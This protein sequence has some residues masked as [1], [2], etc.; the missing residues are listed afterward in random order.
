MHLDQLHL[1]W[2]LVFWGTILLFVLFVL[3]VLSFSYLTLNYFSDSISSNSLFCSISLFFFCYP[4]EIELINLSPNLFTPPLTI[5]LTAFALIN[6]SFSL[7]FCSYVSS[8]SHH[9]PN[10]I[11]PEFIH[12]ISLTPSIFRHCNLHKVQLSWSIF[13]FVSQRNTS[14]STDKKW[15]HHLFLLCCFEK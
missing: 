6:C 14:V 15:T 12:F 10:W 2:L 9:C 11:F 3:S 7:S 1:I 13:N 8:D 4:I 5:S